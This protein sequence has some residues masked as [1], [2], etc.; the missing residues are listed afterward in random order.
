MGEIG[1]SKFA[2][3]G[4]GGEEKLKFGGRQAGGKLLESVLLPRAFQVLCIRNAIA[5]H[6]IIALDHAATKAGPRCDELK[7]KWTKIGV[8]LELILGCTNCG[9]FLTS[10]AD[11]VADP[12]GS[13][14]QRIGNVWMADD[15]LV[16]NTEI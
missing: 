2:V 1:D 6:E 10:L 12:L 11:D 9:P 14:Y 7:V 15:T 16:T 8:L 4:D 5:L 13:G 3:V